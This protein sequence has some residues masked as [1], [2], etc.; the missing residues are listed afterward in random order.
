L[1]A[2]V[3]R[4]ILHS[5]N[6]EVGEERTAV[7]QRTS[8]YRVSLIH[9]SDTQ[10]SKF[11]VVFHVKVTRSLMNFSLFVACSLLGGAL[12]SEQGFPCIK[13]SLT[14]FCQIWNCIMRIKYLILTLCFIKNTH[15]CFPLVSLLA[16]NELVAYL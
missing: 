9:R 13:Q 14:H 4:R 1:R 15:Y 3:V 6:I 8:Q 2:L 11:I 12:N 5:A 7:T 16:V 10:A